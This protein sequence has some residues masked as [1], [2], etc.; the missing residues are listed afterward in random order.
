MDKPDIS[1]KSLDSVVGFMAAFQT[2]YPH[3]VGGEIF[4]CAFDK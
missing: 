1:Q 4:T 2:Y 3:L